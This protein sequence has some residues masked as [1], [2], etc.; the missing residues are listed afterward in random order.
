MP[1]LSL[2]E[3]KRLFNYSNV[4]ANNKEKY[5][6]FNLNSP[7]LMK[8]YFDK[9]EQNIQNRA[10]LRVKHLDYKIVKEI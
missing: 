5:I 9:E 1:E 8:E 10:R 2:K 3:Q 4:V 7:N 6:V